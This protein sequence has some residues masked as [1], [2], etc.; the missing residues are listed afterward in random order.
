MNGH[1]SDRFRHTAAAT[2]LALG[3]AA[4]VLP[5]STTAADTRL[6]LEAIAA[7]ALDLHPGET[8]EVERERKRGRDVY[9]VEILDAARD[10][11]W[12]LRFDAVSGELLKEEAEPAHD[13]AR[14]L[15]QEGSIVALATVADA[16]QRVR[17]GELLEVELKHRRG[18]YIYEVEI[19]DERG[20]V[21]ELKFDAR[22]GNFLEEEADD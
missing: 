18:H 10:T 20:Q 16:A 11:V 19:L 7:R 1:I 15:R 2:L 6:S 4:A 8:L 17:A 14:R 9:D 21:W 5:T 22:D 12:K 3:L 13:H